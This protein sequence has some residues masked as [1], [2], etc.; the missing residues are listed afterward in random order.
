M[1]PILYSYRRCPYAMRA[2]LALAFAGIDFEVREISFHNKPS[3]MLELSPKGT[4][5]VFVLY[6]NEVSTGRVHVIDESLDIV[7]Y[8]KERAEKVSN[9]I[10]LSLTDAQKKRGEDLF[11]RLH[12]HFIPHLNRYK[13]PDRY[14]KDALI[15][16]K[17]LQDARLLYRQS[18]AD[19]V[20]ELS[21]FLANLQEKPSFLL[22]EG[23][24]HYDI[25]L[26]PFIRQFRVTDR[27]WFDEMYAHKPIY[28]WLTWFFEHPLYEK[29]MQKYKP[30][31][32]VKEEGPFLVLVSK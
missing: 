32:D 14:P 9:D 2:R 12:S 18:C 31:L 21:E 27:E 17:G 13:Y 4:V 7:L 5:P 11:Q 20:D 24:S 29:I 23:V 3:E 1:L 10:F 25:L 16:E 26:F 6:D 15:Q 30:W 28:R 8:A 22:G 19:F